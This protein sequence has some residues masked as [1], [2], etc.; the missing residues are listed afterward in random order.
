MLRWRIVRNWSHR[1]WRTTIPH[2]HIRV[3]MT[4]N[5]AQLAYS[6]WNSL[7]T[8]RIASTTSSSTTE[9]TKKNTNS[10]ISWLGN[11]VCVCIVSATATHA[12]AARR[13][14]WWRRGKQYRKVNKLHIQ[15]HTCTTHIYGNIW[16]TCKAVE[17]RRWYFQNSLTRLRSTRLVAV[18]VF[19]DKQ[20]LRA[21]ELECA[22]SKKAKKE[23]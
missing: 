12:T 8:F 16:H 14:R 13:R 20:V 17:C 19:N 9:K 2:W 11:V 5:A 23:K 7:V 1:I 15:S 18:N 3:K 4:A 10:L 21:N 22:I 6:I